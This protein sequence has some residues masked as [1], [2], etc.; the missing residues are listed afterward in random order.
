LS[1]LDEREPPR[2]QPWRAD[3]ELVREPGWL[4]SGSLTDDWL[5]DWWQTSRNQNCVARSLLS[6]A[7]LDLLEFDIDRLHSKERTRDGLS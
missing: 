4:S 2:S 3:D 5:A 6:V 7:T 1:H